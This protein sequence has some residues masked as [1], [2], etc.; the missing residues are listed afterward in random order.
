[1]QSQNFPAEALEG[2]KATADCS[3]TAF[4]YTVEI[5][6]MYLVIIGAILLFTGLYVLFNYLGAKRLTKA[7]KS[8]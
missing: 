3:L 2:V 6:Q 7:K 8:K 5:W 4:G 1:M